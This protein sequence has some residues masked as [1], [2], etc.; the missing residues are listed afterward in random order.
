MEYTP[1]PYKQEFLL[2]L[3]NNNYSEETI[4]NY[5]RDLNFLEAF[6]W[7]ETMKFP[8]IGKLDISRYKGYLKKGEHIQALRELDNYKLAQKERKEREELGLGENKGDSDKVTPKSTDVQEDTGTKR[9]KAPRRDF[10]K[11][12][13]LSPN[14][15]NRMLSALRNYLKFLIDI[16]QD[17]PIPPDAIRLIKTEKKESQ[18][19]ELDDLLALIEAPDQFETNPKVKARNRAILELIFSTGMRISEVVNLDREHL[20][21]YA[22]REDG[23]GGK[24]YIEGKGKKSRFVYLTERAKHWL[25][26]YLQTR[27]DDYPALFIP[28]RGG[29]AG[30]ND[31]ETV[32]IS[33][34]YIQAKIAKYRRKLNIVVPTS[35]H[36]L[37]HGFATYLA[38]EGASPAAI[39]R[40][41]GHESLQ[42][43][44]RYVHASD[45]FAEKAH[46]EH[47]PVQED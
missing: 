47:H 39:Q 6:L 2:E 8:E 43:T 20:E 42:T 4:K 36:S 11:K 35:A 45:R 33:T 26:R 10:K 19:A 1:L 34:N 32:R 30:T 21:I 15:I 28:Y 27:R 22:D 3:T 40:V 12:K 5:E 29:R 25:D 18:V 46:R 23:I 9:S 7:R 16:D 17:V 38:E 31:P 37:R 14:S 13:G 24:M 44:T 41:L